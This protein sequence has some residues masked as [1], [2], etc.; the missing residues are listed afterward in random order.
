MP[1]TPRPL[2]PLPLPS[3]E[4][5]RVLLILVVTLVVVAVVEEEGLVRPGPLLALP[6]DAMARAHSHRTKS[7]QACGSSSGRAR[8]S[9]RVSL[10]PELKGDFEEV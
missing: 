8:R 2:L 5:R 3:R 1:A 6:S 9:S 10:K 7:S 4:T